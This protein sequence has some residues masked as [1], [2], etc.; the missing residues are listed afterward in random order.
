M[1]HATAFLVWFAVLWL[2]WLLLVGEWNAQEW[3][4]AACAAAVAGALGEIARA[5][6]GV[7]PRR[8]IRVVAQAY[9][10]PLLVVVDFGL[11]IWAL[12]RRSHGEFRRADAG[13]PWTA[14]VA[15]YS[16]N[17]YVVE[18]DLVHRLVPFDA[19]QDPA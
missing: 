14:L 17:A 4:A 19:S 8:G 12:A 9:T 15:T 7:D 3:V 6:A 5:C 13:D 10:V 16:P 18:D 2:F 11:L 1:K